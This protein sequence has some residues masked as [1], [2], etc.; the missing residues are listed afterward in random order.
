MRLQSS[1][2]TMGDIQ[3]LRGELAL[4][5]K[6]KTEKLGGREGERDYIFKRRD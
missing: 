2:H 6:V 5:D 1:P 3:D 4:H